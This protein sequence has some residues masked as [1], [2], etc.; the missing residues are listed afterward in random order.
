MKA[1]D[2]HLVR[3]YVFLFSPLFFRI[4]NSNVLKYFFLLILQDILL[5]KQELLARARQLMMN[6]TEGKKLPTISGSSQPTSGPSPPPSATFRSS[7]KTSVNSSTVVAS[8][9][10]RTPDETVTTPP[11]VME[12]DI[13]ADLPITGAPY[14]V[15]APAARP[16]ATNVATLSSTAGQTAAARQR[17]SSSSV[18]KSAGTQGSK[19]AILQASEDRGNKQAEGPDSRRKTLPADEEDEEA[20]ER[21]RQEKRARKEKRRREREE[22]GDTTDKKKK[23]KKKK[24]HKEKHKVERLDS[25]KSGKGAEAEASVS[26]STSVEWAKSEL[27]KVRREASV[28]EKDSEDFSPKSRTPSLQKSAVSWAISKSATILDAF[29]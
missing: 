21:R 17:N 19:Q 18:S 24:K 14:Y 22:G 10:S 15:P 27:A 28:S 7:R 4:F 9:R 25:T 2:L 11:S 23:K 5:R 29:H 16:T 1:S 3:S 6:Q 13:D 26:R 20:R 8:D 12:T